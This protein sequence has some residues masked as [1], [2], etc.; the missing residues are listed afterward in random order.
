MDATS[1]VL[2]IVQLENEEDTKTVRDV[3]V[4]HFYIDFRYML[5][6]RKIYD[7]INDELDPKKNYMTMSMYDLANF[8]SDLRKSYGEDLEIQRDVRNSI[9]ALFYETKYIMVI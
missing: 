4:K 3:P 6:R 8:Y 9:D 2:D 7:T 5:L 1:I